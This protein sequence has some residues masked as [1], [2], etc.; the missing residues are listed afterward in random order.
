MKKETVSIEEA[1]QYFEFIRKDPNPFDGRDFK[2]KL[3]DA[4][5]PSKGILKKPKKPDI[6][7]DQNEEYRKNLNKNRAI[8]RII[9]TSKELLV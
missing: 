3:T 8:R 2:P 5:S 9:E 7:M 1:L 6:Q 4:R